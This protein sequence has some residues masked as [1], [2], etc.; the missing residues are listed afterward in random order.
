MVIQGYDGAIT[1][2]SVSGQPFQ[3]VQKGDRSFSKQAPKVH[4]ARGPFSVQHLQDKD[5]LV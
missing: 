1:S 2:A 4:Y 3:V 5:M